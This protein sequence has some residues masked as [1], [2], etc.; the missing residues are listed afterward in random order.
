MLGKCCATPEKWRGNVVMSNKY[1]ATLSNA[2][3]MKDTLGR[4]KY[5]PKN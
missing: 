2:R 3:E 5:E 1:Q 4:N